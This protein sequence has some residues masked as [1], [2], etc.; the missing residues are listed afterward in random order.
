[1]IIP[2][3]KIDNST[4][5][6]ST[7][8]RLRNHL[9]LGRFSRPAHPLV[10][11]LAVD[12]A[13]VGSNPPHLI[14]KLLILWMGSRNKLGGGSA[15]YGCGIINFWAW[16]YYLPFSGLVLYCTRLEGLKP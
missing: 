5:S 2:H 16:N 6:T 1:M 9:T 8:V 7:T 10:S 15:G 4:P 3:P 12:P 13:A 11:V 14:H